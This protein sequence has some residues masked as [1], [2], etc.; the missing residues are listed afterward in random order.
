MTRFDFQKLTIPSPKR[1]P[2]A[3]A[4]WHGFFPYYAG[5][6]EEFAAALLSSAP[7]PSE[8]VVLDPWNGSGTTT[9]AASRL[10]L[11]SIGCDLNPVM[12]VVARARLLDPAEADHIEPLVEKVIERSRA[13]SAETRRLDPLATWFETETAFVI[14]SIEV[15]IREY[16]VGKMTRGDSE[17]HLDRLT[18]TAATFYVALF[19]VCRDLVSKFKSSNPTWLKYPKQGDQLVGA[20]RNQ[21]ERRFRETLADMAQALSD[22]A[23]RLGMFPIQR[24]RARMVLGDTADG[25]PFHGSADLV[26]TSPPYCTRIDYTAATRVELAVLAGLSRI[27]VGDLS[28]KMIGSTRVPVQ[29]VRA[30]DSFGPTCRQFL[31][32]LKAHPS[33]ASATYYYRTHVDY[34]RKMVRSLRNVRAALRPGGGAVIVVQDSFYKDLHNNLPKAFEEMGQRCRLKLERRDDFAIGR[35]MAGVNPGA[36]SYRDT[37]QAVEAVLCFSRT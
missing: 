36:R 24:G 2:R 12:L 22:E 17:V 8:A 15:A 34:F 9:Y 31:R 33:R 6:P 35:T 19:T 14:R 27:E 3:Q 37:F 18:G 5:Y 20:E 4:G 7:L 32:E 10:G 29:S 11:T 16:L 26:V 28:R 1:R 30:T 25:L 21:I 23:Q 13:R